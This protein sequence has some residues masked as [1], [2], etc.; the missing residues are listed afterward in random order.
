ML[1]IVDFSSSK[2]TLVP[3]YIV[4]MS[5]L[6]LE[7]SVP[8]TNGLVQDGGQSMKSRFCTASRVRIEENMQLKTSA[9]F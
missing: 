9:Y 3:L 1:T 8:R 5:S 2:R 6:K 4:R 7:T